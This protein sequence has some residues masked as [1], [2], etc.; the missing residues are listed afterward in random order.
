[1][2]S[3]HPQAQFQGAKDQKGKG[4]G[5]HPEPWVPEAPAGCRFRRGGYG[6]GHPLHLRGQNTGGKGHRLR[7]MTLAA[8]INPLSGSLG[9]RCWPRGRSEMLRSSRL[10]PEPVVAVPEA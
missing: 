2:A 3:G 9:E 10:D 5:D 7:K 6:A 1:M 4:K 8:R